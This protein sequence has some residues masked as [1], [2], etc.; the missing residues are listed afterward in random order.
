M[1][2]RLLS[3]TCKVQSYVISCLDL[4]L[5]ER[6]AAKRLNMQ[7]WPSV[8]NPVAV[9]AT[10]GEH[11]VLCST[12]MPISKQ[13]DTSTCRR[14]DCVCTLR[15]DNGGGSQSITAGTIKKRNDHVHVH[16]SLC[17]RVWCVD[18]R[19]QYTYQRLGVFWTPV[20][21]TPSPP[22]HSPST[23]GMHL[24]LPR[25]HFTPGMAIGRRR[26]VL[27]G[28]TLIK[29][30]RRTQPVGLCKLHG[31]RSRLLRGQAKVDRVQQC[32]QMNG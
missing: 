15:A 11:G 27:A 19:T 16:L 9:P 8:W 2:R 6:V 20:C 32:C 31:Q 3:S 30:R 29:T 12:G 28:R 10:S 22:H 26:P 17:L 4:T 5:S 7:L 21:C 13:E 23:H 18:R 1:P 14:R 24:L 25:L